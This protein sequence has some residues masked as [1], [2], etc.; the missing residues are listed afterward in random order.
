MP[1]TCGVDSRGV[2]GAVGTS[3]AES[4]IAIALLL[5]LR[6][7]HSV[8]VPAKRSASRDP[9]AVSVVLR[10]AVHRLSFNNRSLGLWVPAFARTTLSRD[11]LDARDQFV[12]RLVHRHLL[13]DDAVHRFRP[14]I[15]VVEDR[16][17]VVF[18]KVER[19]RAA[20]EL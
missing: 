16:E 9:Y 10:E 14:H 15:L 18:R 5:D 6:G 1:Q 12:D 19:L 20:H 2:S 17:L 7:L 13:A 8:V 3:D 4:V 11:L